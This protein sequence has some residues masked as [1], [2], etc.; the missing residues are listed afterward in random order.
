MSNLK[1]VHLK[2]VYDNN[3]LAV[4]D[5]CLS[6]DEGEFIV[7]VG[8]SGCGKTTILYIIA[9]LEKLT[10][11]QLFI[12]GVDVSKI[13]AKDRDIA[14]VFQSH[15]LYPHLTVRKNLEFALKLRKVKKNIIKERVEKIAKELMI[16]ELLNRKPDKLS[17]G[18]M[19]RVAIGKAIVREPKLFLMDEPFANLDIVLRNQMRHEIKKIH[20][21]LN[22]T[23]IFVTHDQME[24][25]SLGTRIV[26]INKAVI[27]QIGT[28]KEVYNTPKNKF[29]AS[30]IG[31]PSMN[32]F[33]VSI[34]EVK[35]QFYINFCNRNIPLTY[36]PVDLSHYVNSKIILGLRAEDFIL[37]D[38]N[39]GMNAKIVSA[40]LI[41]SEVILSIK[42]ANCFDANIKINADDY[43]ENEEYIY[44]DIN[45]KKIH[46]FDIENEENILYGEK[47]KLS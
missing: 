3:I 40:E 34:V 27:Q 2:K 28:P 45:T 7:L 29:V 32:F 46:L 20:K 43:K 9:G 21:N 17:G 22:A 38:K 25:L 30:F 13:D 6:V 12:D 4:K 16:E 42:I 24:A 47:S 23:F 44:I 39:N 10:E 8:P 35:K 11:G 15:T 37:T 19:Q 41:G 14:L 31:S 18:Q 36:I 26:I 1:L 33:E 5:F